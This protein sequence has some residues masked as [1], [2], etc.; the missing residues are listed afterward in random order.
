MVLHVVF[1][2]FALVLLD[3]IIV[4]VVCYFVRVYCLLVGFGLFAD[5]NSVGVDLCLCVHFCCLFYTCDCLLYVFVVFCFDVV[6]F[7]VICDCFEFILDLCVFN[8]IGC[9]VVL[10]ILLLCSVIC[11]LLFVCLFILLT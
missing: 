3:S 6:Y 9:L 4:I 11:C 1:A 2:V 5:I 7:T 8:L 10:D